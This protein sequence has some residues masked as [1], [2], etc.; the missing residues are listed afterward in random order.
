MLIITGGGGFIGSATV[1]N[2]NQLGHDDILVVDRLGQGAKWQN[3]AKRRFRTVLH[4]DDLLT[5]LKADGAQQ[6]ITAV[7]HMGASSSTVETDVDYL[8]GNNLNYSIALWTF[9]AERRIPFIYASSASTYG[10]GAQGFDDSPQANEHLRPLHPYGFSKHRFDSWVLKHVSSG[11]AQPPLWAGLRFFNVYGPQEYHK[12]S[13]GSV[14]F[15]FVPQV[16]ETG[17]I[18]LFKSYKAG[19]ADGE[20][21]RD[22]VYIKDCVDVVTHFLLNAK[23]VRSGIYNVGSGTA[24]SFAEMAKAIFSA[25][26]LPEKLQFVPMPENLRPQ[27]QYFTEA[28]LTHLRAAGG[29][30]KAFTRLEDGV[31]DYVCNYL[32][33]NDVY[34]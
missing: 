25:M 30:T 18:K 22:F 10:D 19:I 15:H 17:S 28:N 16:K 31:H 21:K 14:V 4:K 23:Q 26:H 6:K 11:G 2:L 1:W 7:I 8:M 3:L 24:R 33:A 5:W 34:L 9:C 27:Y 32:L 29:Y 12:G 20:Q 13:Q